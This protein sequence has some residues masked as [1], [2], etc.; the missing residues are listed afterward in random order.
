MRTGTILA[1][2]IRTLALRDS[3]LR[4]RLESLLNAVEARDILCCMAV[5]VGLCQLT[6]EPRY[7]TVGLVLTAV[8]SAN[9]SDS[10]L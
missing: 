10:W 7:L 5:M 3:L 2:N 8:P 9:V 6:W 4:Q 1:R